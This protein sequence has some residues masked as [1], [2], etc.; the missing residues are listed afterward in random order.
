MYMY[1][2]IYMYACNDVAWNACQVA[3][4]VHG[5]KISA[6]RTSVIVRCLCAAH[7]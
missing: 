4:D 3:F 5:R 7:D 2:Y 1:I 6:S